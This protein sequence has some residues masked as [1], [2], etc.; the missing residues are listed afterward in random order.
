MPGRHDW[1]LHMRALERTQMRRHEAR[2]RNNCKCGRQFT[3]TK[4]LNIHLAAM[5][6]RQWMKA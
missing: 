3:T 5:E 2:G 4:G 1:R 6:R